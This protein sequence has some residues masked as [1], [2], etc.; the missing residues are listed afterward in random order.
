[1]SRAELEQ[2]IEELQKS[3]EQL[4]EQIEQKQQH[5]HRLRHNK[6]GNEANQ[7]LL[8]CFHVR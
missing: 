3:N 2:Q 4:R 5:V 1:M 7:V 8:D 6:Q